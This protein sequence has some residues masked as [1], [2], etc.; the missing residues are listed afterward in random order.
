MRKIDYHKDNCKCGVCKAIRGEGKKYPFNERFF[1]TINTEEKAYWLGFI[2]ADGCVYQKGRR[3]ALHIQLCKKDKK[4]LQKFL[5]CL[6]SKRPVFEF[7][8][9]CSIG[10]NS[11]KLIADLSQ[12]GI[13]PRKAHKT[14]FPNQISEYLKQHFIRGIFD[15]D[16][17]ISF[18]QR[19]GQAH[20]N[21]AGTKK[22][23]ITIQKILMK[24]CQLNKTKI[25]KC[26][27]YYLSYGGNRQGKR[28]LNYLYKDATVYLDR[29]Y[30]LYK[31][32]LS[33]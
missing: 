26:S 9:V 1:K 23:L 31:S 33:P 13:V 12:Y 14:Y 32:H 15:G 11:K 4:H 24:K 6:K 21:I 18:E 20:F 29:K 27:T 2:M 8:S 19:N 10:I 25:V 17:S 22:L 3:N 5:N 7:R 16:G 30:Q 28:I